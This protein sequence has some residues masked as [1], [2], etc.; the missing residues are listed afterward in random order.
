MRRAAA[1]ELMS[2]ETTLIS[3]AVDCWGPAAA[4]R[5]YGTGLVH[6][7][8][9][10]D[11]HDVAEHVRHRQGAAV[12]S[13]DSAPRRGR[14]LAASQPRLP[15][16]IWPGWRCRPPRPTPASAAS[17]PARQAPPGAAIGRSVRGDGR[18]PRGL[19]AVFQQLVTERAWEVPAAGGS[20]LQQWPAIAPDLAPHVQAV[21]VRR[22]PRAPGPAA[23]L[24]R[25]RHPT[26]DE[27]RRLVAMANRAAGRYA[28]RSIRVLPPGTHTSAPASDVSPD[29]APSPAEPG[30][31]HTREDASAGYH[32]ALAA[33]PGRQ[34]E[35]RTDPLAPAVQGRDRTTGPVLRARRESEGGVR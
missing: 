26:A 28:V 30:P 23:G 4:E 35:S 34:G 1:A 15:A 3:M 33:A 25:L 6:R 27:H 5:I 21:R 32:Q 14:R 18:E 10:V 24:T 19:A 7:A 11:R 13:T 17:S 20:V 31:V 16:W 2:G 22:R 12:T 29:A 8:R 9:R